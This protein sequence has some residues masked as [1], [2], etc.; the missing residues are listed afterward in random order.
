MIMIQFLLPVLNLNG[1]QGHFRR[2]NGGWRRRG[3]TEIVPDDT[4]ILVHLVY[5]TPENFT[6][7][8][9]YTD[10]RRAYLLPEAARMLYRASECLRVRASRPAVAD[11]RC[12]TSDVGPA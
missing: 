1:K 6:G 12:R 5:A 11:I 8:V 3:L 4:A 2:P 10:L 7:K 9:L